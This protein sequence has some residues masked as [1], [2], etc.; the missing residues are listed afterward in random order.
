MLIYIKI[1]AKEIKT[2]K[3]FFGFLNRFDS[4]YITLTPFS[5]FKTKKFVTIL[6]SPHV[7][8]TAQEQFEYRWYVKEFFINSLKPLMFLS[9]LKRLKT[10]NFSGIRFEVKSIV[11]VNQNN[12]LMLHLLD[13]DTVQL[14][15]TK[16]FYKN[17]SLVLNRYLRL[18]DCYGES[19]SSQTRSYLN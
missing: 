15:K 12:E 7:N 1:S 2:L 11:S 5:K 14:T 10:F 6:K 17:N 18:F 9:F 16:R 3:K 4:L 8:K 13:P 19:Y